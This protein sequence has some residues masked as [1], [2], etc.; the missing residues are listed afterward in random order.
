[1]PSAVAESWIPSEPDVMD[2]EGRLDSGTAPIVEEDV[3]LCIQSGAR[4]MVLDCGSLFYIS[5]AGLRTILTLA[6]AMQKAGG[7][8]AVCGLQ[9]HIQEMFAGCGFEAFI[10]VYRSRSDALAALAR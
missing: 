7:S 5:G 4:R 10:T 2:I 6:R 1:M 3:L 8:F 9:P